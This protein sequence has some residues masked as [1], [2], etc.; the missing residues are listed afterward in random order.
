MSNTQKIRWV[1][2]HEPIDLFLRTA[3]AFTNEI[4]QATNGRID[5]E[6]YTISE[7]SKKFKDG[8]RFDP[9]ALINS[10]EVQM[11]QLYVAKLGEARVSDFY[12][13]ELPFLFK[14]HDHAARVLEGEIGRTLLG[15]T[16]PEKSAIRGLAFT[17]SGGYRVMASSKEIK[18]A[19]DIKGLT[20]GIK[21]NPIFADMANAFGC[22]YKSI[23]ESIGTHEDEIAELKTLASKV[24]TIQTTLPRYS[25]ETNSEIHNHVTNTQHSLYLTTIVI[26]DA[27]WNSLSIEDQMII[28]QAALNSA[29]KE[30][31]WSIEDAR[32]IAEDKNEQEKLGIKSYHELST[33]ESKKLEQSVEGLYKKYDK[34]FS[35]GLIESILKA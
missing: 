26:N 9:M 34:F 25:I 30:R 15:K 1:I 7:Y 10:G 24:N 8:V 11:S 14:N 21:T 12:A 2:F 4:K 13:L 20:I 18:T 35:T 27:F 6:V 32:K 16:L 19:E 22:G 28:G 5:I 3:N 29:R 23:P 33:E 17:Y 31:A